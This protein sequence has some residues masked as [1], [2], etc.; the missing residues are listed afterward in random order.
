[1]NQRIQV[2]VVINNNVSNLIISEL[3]INLYSLN[4]ASK[5]TEAVYDNN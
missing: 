2:V 5:T 4:A 3:L 1:M